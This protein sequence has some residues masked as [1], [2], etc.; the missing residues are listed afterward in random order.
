MD[1]KDNWALLLFNRGD[2]RLSNQSVLDATLTPM[3]K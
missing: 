1:P 3:G 2:G